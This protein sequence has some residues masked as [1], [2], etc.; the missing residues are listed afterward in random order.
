MDRSHAWVAGAVALSVAALGCG[1]AFAQTTADPNPGAV[2]RSTGAPPAAAEPSAATPGTA[3]N[4]DSGRVDRAATQ[5]FINQ[6]AEAGLAEVA[7]G[8][9]AVDHSQS[10]EVKQLAQKMIED[11]TRANDQL[12]MIAMA[13]GYSVPLAPDHH[14]EASLHKLMQAHGR[15]FNVDYSK[16]QASDHREVVSMFRRA[17]Q[18]PRIAPQ[19]REFA[20]M[21]LPILQDHLH[22]ANQLVATESGGNH[23]AG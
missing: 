7:E 12:T 9:Y 15:R 5:K 4:E 17:A 16:A 2:E 19:V 22:M 14:D 3:G 1:A 11:H 20:Q 13:H 18:D 6:A 23:S 8:H 10:P 21:T